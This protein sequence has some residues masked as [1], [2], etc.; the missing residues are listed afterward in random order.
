MR[1]GTPPRTVPR[2]VSGG[3][4]QRRWR[5]AA[6]GRRRRRRSLAEKG[7]VERDAALNVAIRPARA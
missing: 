4:C 1:T 5:H 3:F 6:S 2:F 7:A